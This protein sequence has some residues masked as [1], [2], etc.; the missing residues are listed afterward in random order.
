MDSRY[1]G[2]VCLHQKTLLQLRSNDLNRLIAIIIR[3]LESD[4]RSALGLIRDNH[5][6]WTV[7]RMRYAVL[8]D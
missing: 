5:Q 2:R 4:H 6:Q 8:V 3:N 7:S 1:V